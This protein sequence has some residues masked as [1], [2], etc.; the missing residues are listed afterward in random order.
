MCLNLSEDDW[1]EELIIGVDG[2]HH[3]QDRRWGR[4]RGEKMLEGNE[5]LL[6]DFSDLL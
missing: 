1:I 3:A 2:K 6:M 5:I 4:R